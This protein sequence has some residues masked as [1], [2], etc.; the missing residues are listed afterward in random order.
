MLISPLVKNMRLFKVSKKHAI[1]GG[2]FSKN[3]HPFV[4]SYGGYLFL[5]E[6]GAALLGRQ[7]TA[8]I[9]TPP[10]TPWLHQ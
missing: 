2:R 8:M 1:P 4:P 10:L 7:G 5:L 9:A 3:A 6:V